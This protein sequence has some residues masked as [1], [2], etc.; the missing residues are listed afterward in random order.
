MA[1]DT[2]T[3]DSRAEPS[4]V[5]ALRI[6][7]PQSSQGAFFAAIKAFAPAN[8]FNAKVKRVKEGADLT[9]IDLWRDDMAIGRGNVFEAPDFELAFYIDPKKGGTEQK[10]LEVGGALEAAVSDV[11]GV[12]VVRTSDPQVSTYRAARLMVHL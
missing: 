4:A 1:I 3:F 12:S 9:F 5:Y 2:Y 7:V 6:T 10:V 11:S 8:G